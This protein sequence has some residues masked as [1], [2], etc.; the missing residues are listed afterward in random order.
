[1]QLTKK[2]LKAVKILTMLLKKK[3]ATQRSKSL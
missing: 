3:L 2:R 1:M